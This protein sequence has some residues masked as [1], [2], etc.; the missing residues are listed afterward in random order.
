VVDAS[1]MPLITGGNTN[2]PTMMIAERASDLI[3][4]R[5]PALAGA[6]G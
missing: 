6:A 1:I 5:T 4:G 2:A 3:K